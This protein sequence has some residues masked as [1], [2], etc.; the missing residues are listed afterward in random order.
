METRN[1]KYGALEFRYKNPEKLRHL[2]RWGVKLE[3]IQLDDWMD[4]KFGI[5]NIKITANIVSGVYYLF[6]YEDENNNIKKA[7]ANITIFNQRYCTG[8]LIHYY[9]DDMDNANP[10]LEQL[11]RIKR[12]CPIEVIDMIK[13][14]EEI[15]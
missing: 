9:Y 11:K 6:E 10:P 2:I 13:I 4:G 5:A 8:P 3:Y 15:Y 1:I 12:W 7:V 14:E